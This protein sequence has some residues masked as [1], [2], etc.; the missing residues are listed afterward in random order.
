M[1]SER[2]PVYVLGSRFLLSELI[3][4]PIHYETLG[5]GETSKNCILN[6]FVSEFLTCMAC[7]PSSLY[8]CGI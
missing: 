2:I 1:A 4:S 6:W 7:S 5:Y 8:S 3:W